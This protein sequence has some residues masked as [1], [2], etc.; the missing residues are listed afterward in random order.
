MRGRRCG[1]AAMIRWILLDHEIDDS[2]SERKRERGTK[3][4]EVIVEVIVGSGGGGGGNRKVLMK[5]TMA[6]RKSQNLESDK[7]MS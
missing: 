2:A 1:K 4:R 3:G 5:R 6:P 7:R